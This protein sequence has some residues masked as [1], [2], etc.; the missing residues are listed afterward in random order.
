[1]TLTDGAIR[2][3]K[4]GTKAVKH[5]DSGGLYLDKLK[6]DCVR[7]SASTEVVVDG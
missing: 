5:Y 3:A 2:K 4:P 6:S 7:G 1:M